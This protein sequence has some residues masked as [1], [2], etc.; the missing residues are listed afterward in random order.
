MNSTSESNPRLDF[1]RARIGQSLKDGL[2]PLGRWLSGT[3]RAVD[4][5]QISVEFSV[6]EDMTNP[7]GVL[8]GGAAAAIM[9]DVVGMMVFTLGRDY[10]YTSVNLNCDF[11]SAARLGDVLTAN[12]RVVR[13]GRNIIHCEC[14]IV[15]SEG[16]IVA[17]CA[18][19]LIQTGVKLPE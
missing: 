7:M 19:N 1:F 11:L 13:A 15:K 10:G 5:G 17:K 2:S 8:H 3:L 12:A 16:K 9:D 18:S 14:Q 6:R 4:Y